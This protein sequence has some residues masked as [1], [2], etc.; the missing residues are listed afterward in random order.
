MEESVHKR[1]S[2]HSCTSMDVFFGGFCL[3]A[4]KP[5]GGIC[6]LLGWKQWFI[7]IT[8]NPWLQENKTFN[9]PR[10]LIQ[11]TPSVIR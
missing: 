5:L 1:Q 6:D 7:E 3:F 2:Y 10:H 4:E 8:S 11:E 9:I